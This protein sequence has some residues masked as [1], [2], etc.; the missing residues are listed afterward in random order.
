[1][2]LKYLHQKLGQIEAEARL[3]AAEFPMSLMIERQQRILAL[4]RCIR[5][6]LAGPS[7][8]DPEATVPADDNIRA[9]RSA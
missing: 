6:E 1:M 9:L 3:T 4:V 7:L 2:D 5:A 8:R